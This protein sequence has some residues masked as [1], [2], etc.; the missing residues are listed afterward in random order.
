ML[1]V[2][3]GEKGGT[4]K[5]ALSTNMAVCMATRGRDVLL[6]DSDGQ[7]SSA[8]WAMKRRSLPNGDKM[9]RVNWAEARGEIFE[10]LMDMKS[11]YE[12]V[13]VD[14]GGTDAAELRYALAA[15]DRVYS[16]MVP[17]ECDLET[18]GELN[19][20]IKLVKGMGNPTLQS[21]V[22]LNLCPTHAHDDEVAE[23]KE[24]LAD[25]TELK[26]CETS[27]SYR[28][29]IRTAYRQRISVIEMPLSPDRRTRD[30][31]KK[32]CEEIWAF[33]AEITGDVR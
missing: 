16:P 17:S 14:V 23:A 7:R 27:I 32:A 5:T 26:L 28:K 11:R 30:A 12:V 29:P 31:A 1:Y 21:R 15:A 25:F 4:G 8:K 10:M 22:I 20:V 6:I 9:V 3:G 2:F 18:A 13:I 19:D 24:F 33:Y